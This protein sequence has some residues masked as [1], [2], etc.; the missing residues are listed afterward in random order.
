MDKPIGG[1]FELEL[2]NYGSFIH[3]DGILLNS[4]KS[5][6][7]H[8]LRTLTVKHVWVPYFTCDVV[9]L[10][11]IK[12][13]IPFSFYH[14]DYHLELQS[15]ISL[16]PKE[17]LLYTNYFGIKDSYIE[18]LAEIYNHHLIIDNSQALFSNP[19]SGIPTFYSPR[20][21]VGVP[22]GGI[23]YCN[24]PDMWPRY[25][26]D[27][28]YYRCSNLLKRLELD[29]SNGYS[30]Y[31]NN[32]IALS[33]KPIRRMSA[34][35]EKLLNSIDFEHIKDAR[36]SNYKTLSLSLEHFNLFD[37]PDIGS[38]QCP[39]AYPF[40]SP[41]TTLKERLIDNKVFVATYWPSVIDRV[42]DTDVEFS[43]VKNLIALPCDQR[44]D[45]L[46]MSRIIKLVLG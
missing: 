38:F 42:Q 10:P 17:Y 24:S 23:A 21:Y 13:Q 46:D 33:K 32:E 1:Y 40:F 18:Q 5:A 30:E 6:W 25:K 35:T 7:E 26:Q 28:S 27:H 11:L 3:N 43:L 9:L 34:L 31:K 29:P 19:I 41:D 45:E 37:L 22:D 44:Y 36:I 2:T 16:G 8:I 20:K 12:L 15:H 39:M 14:I 4:G